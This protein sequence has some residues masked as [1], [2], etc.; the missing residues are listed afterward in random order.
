MV[1]EVV[2]SQCGIIFDRHVLGQLK[3]QRD[4]VG[5][6]VRA[7]IHEKALD[8]ED[9]KAPIYDQLMPKHGISPWWLTEILPS[10]DAWQT[11]SGEWVKKWR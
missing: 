10:S 1:R 11:K 4:L 2:T 9:M 6:S 3:I 7:G 5:S 8:G